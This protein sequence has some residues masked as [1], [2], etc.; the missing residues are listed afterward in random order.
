MVEAVIEPEDSPW[1]I[2]AFSIRKHLSA[3]SSAEESFLPRP[4]FTFER[5]SKTRLPN[6][7]PFDSIDMG[8]E[9]EPFD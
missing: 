8:T 5:Q 3:A 2:A 6:A 4:F 9:E 7:S 1:P